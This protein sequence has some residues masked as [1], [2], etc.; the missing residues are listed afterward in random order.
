MTIAAEA[1][2]VRESLSLDGEWEVRQDSDG[3]DRTAIVPN[4]WQAEFD[5][6]RYVSG[7]AVYAR[8]FKVPD[9]WNDDLV[10]IRFGAVNYL[11]EVRLNGELLGFHEG[12]YLPFEFVLP[13]GTSGDN[14]L[15]VTATL[16]TGDRHAYP[17]FPFGE[18]PH[19]KQSWYG[20]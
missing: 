10:V 3:I 11:A 16:P 9:S 12:G 6:L 5:D 14:R 7:R 15:E 4:P 20:P 8:S 19:G 17:A 2:G 18:I 13:R 1:T